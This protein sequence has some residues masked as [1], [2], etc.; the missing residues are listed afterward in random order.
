MGS[1]TSAYIMECEGAHQVSQLLTP[2]YD[3]PIPTCSN[4]IFFHYKVQ[5]QSVLTIQLKF[6]FVLQGIN[7]FKLLS[8]TTSIPL[9]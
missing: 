1:E 4:L 3:I 6:D 5:L 2:A 8:L 7:R 9:R